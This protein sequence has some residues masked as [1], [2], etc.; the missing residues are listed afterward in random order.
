MSLNCERLDDFSEC[1]QRL[2]DLDALLLQ[3]AFTTGQTL[4]L[5][6][7]E[8]DNLKLADDCVVRVV[9]MNLLDGDA[10]D[11]V[12]AG[13]RQ[14]HLVRAEYFVLDSMVEQVKYFVLV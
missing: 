9:G 8:I 10:E 4:S 7:C 3:L 6:A 13:A 14:V 2:V 12:R 1:K 11:C 5:T